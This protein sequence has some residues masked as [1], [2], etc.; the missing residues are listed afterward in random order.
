MGSKIMKTSILSKMNHFNL[1]TLPGW[2][3]LWHTVVPKRILN[4]SKIGPKTGRDNYPTL[5]VTYSK[6]QV[7]NNIFKIF[8]LP[9]KGSEARNKKKKL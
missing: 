3:P 8:G 5:E 9:P 7:N 4:W 1:D 6:Y 2:P